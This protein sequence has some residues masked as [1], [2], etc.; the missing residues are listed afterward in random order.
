MKEHPSLI[1]FVDQ[2]SL[3]KKANQFGVD[4]VALLI[5]EAMFSVLK[6][7]QD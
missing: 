1:F 2:G 6:G 5:V 4:F 7:D 3:A